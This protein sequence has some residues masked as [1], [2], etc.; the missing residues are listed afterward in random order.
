[1]VRSLPVPCTP[2]LPRTLARTSRLRQ[3]SPP[4]APSAQP[5][6]PTGWGTGHG[7]WKVCGNL[8]A[9]L[10]LDLVVDH[11][12]MVSIKV[13]VFGFSCSVSS[14]LSLPP[15]GG[16]TPGRHPLL[17]S[18]LP[19]SPLLSLPPH[20]FFC[21]P[22]NPLALLPSP[23]L[24]P[25]LPFPSLPFLSLRVTCLS[26]HSPAL[27]FPQPCTP[28]LLAPSLPTP[29]PE[30]CPCMSCSPWASSKRPPEPAAPACQRQRSLGGRLGLRPHQVPPTC[31][32]DWGS[33]L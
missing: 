22:L 3:D 15:P 31:L 13:S 14:L 8:H 12:L 10:F 4:P 1:M 30:A 9:C 19:G 17:S 18:L 7:L 24:H 33:S 20:P 29:L 11:S 23:H 27:S 6:V 16:C 2:P 21:Y 5:Q 25:H 28:T 32:A 26:P